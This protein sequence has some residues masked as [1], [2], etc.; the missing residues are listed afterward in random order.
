MVVLASLAAAGLLTHSLAA[1]APSTPSAETV[2]SHAAVAADHA[3][4]SQAGVEMLRR[5]G[6]A[7]DA[8]VAAS[9]CL[10]V[11]RPYSCGIGGGGFMLIA[12]PARDGER[13]VQVAID[14]RE[15]APAAVASDYYVALGDPTAS[16]AGPHAVGTPGTVAGLLWA[17]RHYGTLDRAAVLA[18]AIRAAENGVPADASHV[19]AARALAVRLKRFGHLRASA[20]DIWGNL[21]RGGEIEPGD[22]I[23]NPKQARALRLIAERGASAFYEG[24]IA[25]A[26]VASMEAHGGSMTRED[27]ARYAVRVTEPLRGTFRGREVLTMPPPSSGGI[28]SLQIL[29]L[30]ERRLDDLGPPQHNRPPYVHLLVESMKHAF[31]DRSA[32]MADPEFVDVPTMR[33][34]EPAYL[35]ERAGAIDM[36]RTRGWRHYGSAASAADDGGTSHLSVIDADGMAV[37]CT[38]TINLIYGSLVTVPGFGFALNNQMDDFTTI[39]DRP[40]AFG[41]RQ[42]DRNL[43]EAGKRPLSSMSPTIVLEQ[44]RPVI[45]AGASGGPRI[46]TGTVQSVLN[47]LLFDMPPV[48]AVG[49]AR[50]HHQWRPD[51]LQFEARWTDQPTIAALEALGHNTARRDRVGVVQLIRNGPDGIRAASD[52]RKG[53]AP[54]GY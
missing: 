3:L 5:G 51:V 39:P 47:C 44:G 30:L 15:T 35:Q 14:Y 22:V 38:E 41:L 17:L 40:N 54:A 16:R 34:L 26:I 29:G 19:S 37:A 2:Y 49:A 52:P 45:I 27:L 23:R 43:P 18:P 1:R 28:A 9:F 33:L 7:V 31:A 53:G 32:W 36:D 11:V 46:I 48:E 8:A 10:S 21:C 24:E 42:S 4:A 25:E 20:A 13:P 6:N 12:T 50:F